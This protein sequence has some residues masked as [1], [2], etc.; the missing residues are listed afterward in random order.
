[1]AKTESK[2]ENTML[3]I[4]FDINSPYEENEIENNSQ[5][6]QPENP[7][8]IMKE[9]FSNHKLLKME[10][11]ELKPSELKYK[12]NFNFNESESIFFH[13][14]VI[15]NLSFIHEISLEADGFVIFIN[16]ED[17]KTPEKL[18]LLLKYIAEGCGSV[19]TK[20]YIIG[21]YTKDILPSCQ[22]EE[23][24][25][26]IEEK[27]L[28]FEYHQIKYDMNDNNNKIHDCFYQNIISDNKEKNKK[29]KNDENYE[30]NL[31]EIIE[32]IMINVY[33]FKMSV[34]YEPDKK[35]F[36]KKEEKNPD[37]SK[38]HCKIF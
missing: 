16:L 12:F 35:K 24:E 28:N 11:K 21:I 7:N 25:N 27:N 13:F 6:E 3:Y 36:V 17:E 38:S 1:M 2:A 23:L 31:Q 19:V 18:E 8:R 4:C 26:S 22:K 15:N 14:I 33:E 32:I 34:I 20:I 5:E 29:N 30:Y 10:K 9:F 37:N